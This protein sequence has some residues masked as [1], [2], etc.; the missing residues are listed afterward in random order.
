MNLIPTS[1]DGAWLIEQ[2]KHVD[3]RGSFSRSYCKEW[4]A[5][6]GLSQDMI[7]CSESWNRKASTLRGMHYQI[8]PFEETKMIRCLKGELYDVIIDLRPQSPTYMQYYATTL[9]AFDGN[10]VYAPTGVAHGFM[11][12]CDDTIVGYTMLEG[13]YSVSHARGVRW[14]DPAFNIV[15]PEE[16][17]VV[18]SDRDAHYPDY[19]PVYP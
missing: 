8:S 6:Q 2:H 12:L 13:K 3:D 5:K 14:N 16:T 17:P 11:T 18:I 10:Q 19:A 15:W 4:L 7:Q 1:I 9:K